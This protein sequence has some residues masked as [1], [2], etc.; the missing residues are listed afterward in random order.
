MP[1]VL[2][3]GGVE[4]AT[5]VYNLWRDLLVATG[6]PIVTVVER[7]RQTERKERERERQRE[8]QTER[9]DRGELGL[10]T[11]DQSLRLF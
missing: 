10:L 9:E 7:Q 11:L 5:L 6:R 2:R 1:W 8:R 4:P 3:L